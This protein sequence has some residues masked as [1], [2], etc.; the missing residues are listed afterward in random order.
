[1]PKR[2]KRIM[3]R[4]MN[5][6]GRNGNRSTIPFRDT[7]TSSFPITADTGNIRLYTLRDLFPSLGV[8]PSQ[9]RAIIWTKSIVE[10]I[11]S[12]PVLP[13]FVNIGVADDYLPDDQ[14]T[15]GIVQRPYRLTSLVN[16]IRMTL[17]LVNLKTFI[18]NVLRAI[19]TT[20]VDY[21]SKL[22]LQ[23]L[24]RAPTYGTTAGA[25]YVLRITSFCRIL[26]QQTSI[27]ITPTS[28][29]SLS[30]HDVAPKHAAIEDLGEERET[31]RG[32]GH[33]LPI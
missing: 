15:T 19:D 6:N 31:V 18:P 33:T 13:L 5:R 28:V 24:H 25:E 29:V 14:N 32:D 7:I 3:K 8:V 2:Q 16:P 27:L 30:A 9:G 20:T 17:N 11:P 23:I 26:P 21:V 12:P 4:K 1:M 10:F 22:A